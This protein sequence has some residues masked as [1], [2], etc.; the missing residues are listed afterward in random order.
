MC[1]VPPFKSCISKVRKQSGSDCFP[2]VLQPHPHRD[3]VCLPQRH[4]V[5]SIQQIYGLYT[6][7]I[8]AVHIEECQDLDRNHEIWSE[9][10]P[11]GS[12]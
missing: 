2:I 4:C 9:S 10:G 3:T 1:L 5:V 6:A 7:D 12:V 11:Y 8:C